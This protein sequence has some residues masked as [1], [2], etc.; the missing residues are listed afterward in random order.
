MGEAMAAGGSQTWL[1]S[2]F[3][4]EGLPQTWQGFWHKAG[5]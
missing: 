2:S 4:G 3:G 5:Q 1:D